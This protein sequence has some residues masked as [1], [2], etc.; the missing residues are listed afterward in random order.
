MPRAI[1]RHSVSLS[2]EVF[3]TMLKTVASGQALDGPD[4]RQF[5]ERFAQY[6]GAKRAIGISSAR[7]GLYIALRALGL[8]P[9]DEVILA[10]YNFHVIPLIIRAAGLRPVFVDV[11]P[12]TYNID[13]SLV[14]KNISPKSRAV[15]ATHLFGQPCDMGPLLDTAER[16]EL[17]VIEDC[18][19]SLGAEYEGRKVGSF[20]DIGLFSFGPG[21]NMPCFGGGMITANDDNISE[22]VRGEVKDHSGKFD[23]M[24]RIL[25][26]SLFYLITN[27]GLF[28]YLLYPFIRIVD[29]MSS[30]FADRS[31][32]ENIALPFKVPRPFRL[33]NLQAAVG[34]GQLNRLDGINARLIRNAGLFDQELGT[35]K[36]IRIP[37]VHPRVKH[38]YLYYRV[39]EEDAKMFRRKL[40]RKGIDTKRDD[41]SNC[42]GLDVFA[43]CRTDC[44]VAERLPARS[45]GIPNTAFLREADILR[46]AECIR[47][48]GRN[49]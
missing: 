46:I 38:I 43:P 48:T 6:I 2:P 34:L 24:K 42:A 33:T 12:G 30:D 7:A 5:E 8:E 27:P 47:E 25:I 49:T 1:P 36:N 15:I 9:G 39:L 13:I 37:E 11:D 23:L 45:I 17:K 22:R 10:S 29:R 19:H 4:L 26:T 28:P 3:R 18:A 21:K 40:L 41:M 20:G 32:E 14:K 31:M 16:H 35:V 44:P